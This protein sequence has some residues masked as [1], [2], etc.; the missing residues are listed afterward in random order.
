MLPPGEAHHV[1]NVLRAREGDVVEVADSQGRLFGAEVRR[2]SCL[3]VAQELETVTDE[4]VEIVLYQAVPKGRH[5]D[6]VA[7]KATE[8]GVSAIVPL[9]TEHGVVRLDSGGDKVERWRRVCVAAARQALRHRVPEVRMPATFAEAAEAA[10]ERGVLLH[11]EPGLARVEEQVSSGPVAL[12]VGPEGGWSAG[13]M[14]LARGAGMRF[15]QIGPYRLR[16]ETAGIVAVAR[17]RAAL[18][19]QITRG[20]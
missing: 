1:R 13:E 17:A 15:A 19:V 8:V 12:L 20:A 4:G 16:S 11:N 6:L 3:L 9:I 5:M 7:E 10:G 14:E 18:E 2:D